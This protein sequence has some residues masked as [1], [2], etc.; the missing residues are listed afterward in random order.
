[1]RRKVLV[2]VD[3]QNDFCA[4]GAL[5]VEGGDAVVRVANELM[6]ADVFDLVVA[7]Q[8][9][10]PQNHGS[11]ASNQGTEPF[12]AGE[13]NGIQQV[14]WPDHCVAGSHGADLHPEL[15]QTKIAAI[16]R[17]GM[18]PKID[19]YSGFMDNDRDA[20][21]HQTGLAQ[22]IEG[23]DGDDQVYVMGLATDYCV[24]FT[25]LD[26]L[27]FNYDTYLIEDGCRGVNM[28]PDDSYKAID[29]MRD[30]FAGIVQ[31]KDLL[32]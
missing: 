31:S 11:F 22:I 19:S 6:R 27:D 1:M 24:K 5:E 32:K 8:D 10:H 3:I 9:W 12:S 30:E 18:N 20:D 4:D 23:P 7:T 28:E 15:D 14:W 17:K 16:I 29:E 13:L 21:R 25:V 2:L 26:S